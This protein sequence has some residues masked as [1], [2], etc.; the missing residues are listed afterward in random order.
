[1]QFDI[2]YQRVY[3]RKDESRAGPCGHL[4]WFE[5]EL[6]PMGSLFDACSPAIGSVL[7]GVAPFERWGP[8]GGS[9]ARR[10]NP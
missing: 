7:G 5:S 2:K 4:A 10:K 9:T 1:M 6:L 3:I 8:T